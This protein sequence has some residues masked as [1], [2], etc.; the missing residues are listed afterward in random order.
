VDESLLPEPKEPEPRRLVKAAHEGSGGLTRK[1][2]LVLTGAVLLVVVLGFAGFAYWDRV[3]GSAVGQWLGLK[4]GQPMEQK[5]ESPMTGMEHGAAQPQGAKAMKDMVPGTVM[6]SVQKQQMIGVRSGEAKIM[7]LEK[8]I[9]TV[10][11]VDYDV[12][13][14]ARVHTK[15]PGW[16][17]KVYVDCEGQLI[18]RGQPLFTVYS[19]ELVSTQEEYLLALRA[20]GQL[21]ESNFEEVSRG[22]QSLLASTRRRLELWDISDQQIDELARTGQVQKALTLYAPVDGVVLKRNAYEQTRITTDTNVYEIADLSTVWVYADIYEYEMPLIKQGQMASM[23]LSYFP[24]ETSR[25]KVTYV[26]PYLEGKT[27][28]LKVRMEFPNP[29]LKLRPDMYADVEIKISLGKSLVV[30]EEAV[31]DSGVRQLVFVDKGN[32]Y[33]EPRDVK[34]GLKLD[35]YYQILEGLKPGEKV[36]TSANFLV[37]S[38]SRLST[39][40]G[41]MSHGK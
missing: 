2:W 5:A 14:V 6:L 8:T 13:K 37:D 41:G 24:G 22:A 40:T 27:R 38:E 3:S 16:I 17:E 30:S 12:T 7:P 11:R 1:R 23:K 39:A 36:V 26:Y 10:G 21:V 29:N 19:P 34:L 28:T 25:G 18:K 4:S 32:G 35:H 9:R 20:K 33:F 31:M 15:I